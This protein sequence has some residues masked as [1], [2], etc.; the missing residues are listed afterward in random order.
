MSSGVLR[1][2]STLREL[3]FCRRQLT[4][5]SSA[6]SLALSTASRPQSRPKRRARCCTTP[7]LPMRSLC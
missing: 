2:R 7:P 1:P 6:F 4:S 5:A 3:K